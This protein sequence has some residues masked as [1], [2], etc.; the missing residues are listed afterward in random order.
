MIKFL[1]RAK[2][3]AT[4]LNSFIILLLPVLIKLE[5]ELN[6]VAGVNPTVVRWIAWSITTLT[7]IVG[8]LRRTTPVAKENQGLLPNKGA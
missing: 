7:V 8:V 1:A 6:S 2:V 3:V 4:E 5:S